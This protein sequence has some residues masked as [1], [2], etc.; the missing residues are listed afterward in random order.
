[1]GPLLYMQCMTSCIYQLGDL[2]PSATWEEHCLIIALRMSLPTASSLWSSWQSLT[3]IFS[4]ADGSYT[5]VIMIGFEGLPRTLQSLRPRGF[6]IFN[7][8]IIVS[9]TFFFFQTSVSEDK[10]L[11]AILETF[12]IIAMYKHKVIIPY[13]LNLLN[14]SN[15]LMVLPPFH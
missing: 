12:Y 14:D 2:L 5:W 6:G 13:F 7:R 9:T 15:T 11:S 1:M 4:L 10:T 8:C 3:V